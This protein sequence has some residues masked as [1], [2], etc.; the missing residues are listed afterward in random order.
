M[1]QEKNDRLKE[2]ESEESFEELLDR[3]FGAP[4]RFTPG[5]QIQA[6]ITQVTKE[7]VFIDVGG[8]SDGFIAAT[9]F[10]DEVGEITVQEGGTVN[11]FFLSSKDSGML[12]TTKL[13]D[14]S[15]GTEHLQEAYHSGIPVEGVIEKEI[16]G[17]FAVKIAGNIRAFCP[18][19]QMELRRVEDTGRYIGRREI[20]KLIEYGKQGRN[21]VVSHRVV[22]EEERQE[23]KERLRSVL[24]E[25][26][27]VSGEITSIREFGAF[28][29]IGGLEGLIPISEVSWGRV[30]D[31]QNVLS[32]GQQVEVAIKKLDWDNDKFSFSLKEIQPDPWNDLG[33]KYPEG[34]V[35]A[36]TVSR[37]APFGA[38][39]T[40]EPGID[41]LVHISELGKGKRIQH[42]RDVLEEKQSI[43]VKITRIDEKQKRIG[44][45][46]VSDDGASEEADYY[47]K[48][49]A[50]GA[51]QSSGSLG[52]L[53][54]ILQKKMDEKKKT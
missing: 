37:L 27:T 5:E 33:L 4:V 21:I 3:S 41:G 42:P 48:H 14:D 1:N 39:V 13:S 18:Y 9:E 8:K 31:I 17:G 6:V 34:S 47:K 53:G 36:G 22:L 49:M 7:W 10:I 45:A 38:F 35:H 51:K 15:T 23:Q 25:G 26:M 52:T 32:I 54:E 12:F 20:F 19:S 28:V 46:L 16:K 50:S 29:D 2:T 40:L 11:A 43:E 24:Q 44:M 30:E